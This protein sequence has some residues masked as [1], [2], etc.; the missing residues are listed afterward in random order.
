M[1]H[2]ERETAQVGPA[3]PVAPVQSQNDRVSSS[4]AAPQLPLFGS[5]VSNEQKSFNKQ[6]FTQMSIGQQSA[7]LSGQPAGEQQITR[8][9]EQS[10]GLFGQPFTGQR[11]TNLFCHS[12]TGQQSTDLFGQSSNEKHSTELFSQPSKGQQSM[13]NIFVS[14]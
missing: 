5:A 12:S 1:F 4:K 9:F 7:G 2:V 6:P 14:P 11:P 3:C 10:T 13:S 8:V